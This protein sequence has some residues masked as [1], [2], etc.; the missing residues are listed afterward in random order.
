MMQQMRRDA[1]HPRVAIIILNWNGWEDTIEC[2]ES[3]LRIDYPNCRIIVVDNGS[4]DDSIEKIKS[5]ARGEITVESS[6]F[7]LD[8]ST[9]PV[10]LIEHD[11]SAI[12]S[13]E[14]PNQKEN[15]MEFPNDCSL[16]LL[17]AKENRGFAGGNNIGIL[18]AL[19]D[20][21]IEYIWLLNNDTIVPAQALTLLI[22]EYLRNPAVGILS[23]KICYYSRPDRIWFAGGKLGY[24]RA[25]GYNLGIDTLD[26]AKYSGL[27]LCTFITGCSMLIKR[28]LIETIGLMDPLYFLYDEDVDFSWRTIKGG[29]ELATYMDSV[30]YHKVSSSTAKGPRYLQTYYISR[31][32]PYFAAKYHTQFQRMAFN[33]FWISSRAAKF[34]IWMMKGRMDLIRATTKGYLDYRKGQMGIICE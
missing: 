15:S 13:G 20:R 9:K 8:P 32:R 26:N 27:E 23:P 5:W 28:Q 22:N 18:F 12:E 3:L 11:Q 14:L 30:I 21:T 16:V 4:N 7:E 33:L 1:E 17:K 24:L 31:N 2:L 34:F 6:F 19:I 25:A 29:W 10:L